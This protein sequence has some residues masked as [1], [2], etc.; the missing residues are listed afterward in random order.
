MSKSNGDDP[1]SP[2]T[3]EL[4]PHALADGTDTLEPFVIEEP[5]EDPQPPASN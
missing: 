3:G 2:V 5:P 4:L 1:G